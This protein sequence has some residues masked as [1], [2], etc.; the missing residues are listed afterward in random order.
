MRR[1]PLQPP[2]LS[3]STTHLTATTTPAIAAST[4][5]HKKT[6]QHRYRVLFNTLLAGD[7]DVE[8]GLVQEDSPYAGSRRFG[9]CY[10]DEGGRLCAIGTTLEIEHFVRE[11][12]G[13]MCVCA[14]AVRARRARG[15]CVRA[16]GAGIC[17][18]AR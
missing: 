16:H 9:M 17:L 12:G 18:Q 2:L 11:P 10:L 13:R 4:N 5:T 7:P 6:H 8:E 3:C 15:P 1:A 14:S